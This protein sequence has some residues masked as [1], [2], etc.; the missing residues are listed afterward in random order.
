M[1]WVR[2]RMAFHGMD[3]GADLPHDMDDGAGLP[4]G[5][6]DVNIYYV[7]VLYEISIINNR[8]RKQNHYIIY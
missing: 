3:D 5:M 8:K 6:G 4:H 7:Y 1:G 2:A